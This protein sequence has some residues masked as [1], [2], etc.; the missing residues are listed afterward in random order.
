MVEQG[1][2]YWVHFKNRGAAITGSHPALVLQSTFINQSGIKTVALA[3]ISSNT[4]LG[5]IPGNV[6]IGKEGGLKKES[7]V[8][9]TQLHSISKEELQ[10]KIGKISPKKLEEVFSGIDHLF[11]R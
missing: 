6:V 4:K 5:L 2:I 7:V 3:A 11:G 8:N 1:D 9:V 10:Q